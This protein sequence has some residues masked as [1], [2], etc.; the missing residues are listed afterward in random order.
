LQADPWPNE[1][2]LCRQQLAQANETIEAMIVDHDKQVMKILGLQARIE[3]ADKQDI[4]AWLFHDAYGGLCATR[5]GHQIDPDAVADN[6]TPVYTRPPITPERELALL[7][8]IEQKDAALKGVLPF[9]V[10]QVVACHGL[11]CREAVCESCSTDAD[12]AAQN[13]CNAY[14]VAN[15]ALALIPDLS[16]LKEHDD[17]NRDPDKSTTIWDDGSGCRHSGGL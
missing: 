5:I 12:V 4:E 8:V 2:A 16:A 3:V 10:T 15:A 13:A 14:G 1:F 11:K 9:V 6:Y 7:A 17:G